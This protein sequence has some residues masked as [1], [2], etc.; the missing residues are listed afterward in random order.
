[1]RAMCAFALLRPPLRPANP[2]RTHNTTTANSMM[3]DWKV[4]LVEDNISEFY[5]DFNGPK[6]SAFARV[7]CV[8]RPLLGVMNRNKHKQYNLNIHRATQRSER[9]P[10]G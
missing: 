7:L 3:S 5:I 4:E 2:T 9:Q 1:M 10:F 8:P 6:D